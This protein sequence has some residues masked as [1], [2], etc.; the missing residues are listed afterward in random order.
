MKIRA[1]GYILYCYLVSTILLTLVCSTESLAAS[2][3]AFSNNQGSFSIQANNLVRMRSAEVRISYQVNDQGEKAQV[4]L[5]PNTNYTLTQSSGPGYLD[6]K[7]TYIE[8]VYPKGNKAGIA[9]PMPRLSGDYKLLAIAKIPGDI[10]ALSASICSDKAG[11][12]SLQGSVTNPVNNKSDD[13]NIQKNKTNETDMADTATTHETSASKPNIL[14]DAGNKSSTSHPN[15]RITNPLSEGTEI[16]LRTGK[17]SQSNADTSK[18]VEDMLR[19]IKF[20]RRESLLERFLTSTGEKTAKLLNHLLQSSEPFVIQDPPL[21]LSNGTAAL[22]LTVRPHGQSKQVSQF[23][24]SGGLC[25]DLKNGGNGIWILEIVPERGTLT[26]SVTVL[27]D[28]EAIEY[29]MAVA[30]PLEFFDGAGAGAEQIEYVRI[31]NEYVRAGKS[32]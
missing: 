22:R 6:F 25:T 18:E 14:P 24:I 3:F 32:M 11:C 17:A 12:E 29:P 21:L 30:P 15:E 23:L 4:T 10:T 28:K 27:V 2:V 1:Q 5:Y 8:K 13:K 20:L 7:L 16:T 31:A 19:P 26:T 9:N